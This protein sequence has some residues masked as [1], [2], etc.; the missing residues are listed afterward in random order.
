[1]AAS[2][3]STAMLTHM[4]DIIGS[5]HLEHFHNFCRVDFVVSHPFHKER[6]MDGARSF[7]TLPVKMLQ[8]WKPSVVARTGAAIPVAAGI[9][10]IRI[11]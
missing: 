11:A 8:T 7:L 6:E 4:A 3:P 5:V 9:A 10:S 1:L 2:L